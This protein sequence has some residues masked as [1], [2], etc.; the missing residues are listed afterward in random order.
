M[1]MSMFAAGSIDCCV[2][3]TVLF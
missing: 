1:M 2:Y 3:C